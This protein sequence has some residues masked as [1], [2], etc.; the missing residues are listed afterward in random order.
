MIQIDF[1]QISTYNPE[2]YN[3]FNK[4]NILIAQ[5]NVNNGFCTGI[6]LNGFCTEDHNSI[7]RNIIYE[8][9]ILG[10]KCFQSEEERNYHLKLIAESIFDYYKDD[11]NE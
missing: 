11:K 8:S 10:D 2:S 9:K 3:V 6:L 5:I 4:N 7:I 1:E